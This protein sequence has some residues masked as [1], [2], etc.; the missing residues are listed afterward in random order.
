MS[1]QTVP[2]PLV[3]DPFKLLHLTL[4]PD[5]TLTRNPAV[6]LTVEATP[7]PNHPTPVLS[8]DIPINPSKNTRARIYLPR[9]A[10]DF[11]SPPATKLPLIVYYHGG[12][13]ILSSVDSIYC[14]DFC[15]NIA[16]KIPAVIVSAG[17]RLAPE[18]RLPA[19]YDDAVEALYSIKSSSED[20]LVKYA[21]FSNC[22]LMGTSAG[23]NIAYHAGLRAATV[24]DELVPLRIRGLILH[25]P[26]F[27]G[28]Q[29]SG[30]ELRNMNVPVFPLAVADMMW[31]LSLPAGADRDHE[32]CNPTV[33]GGSKLLVKV[34]SEGW[35]V[36]MIGC[37]GDLLVDRQKELVKL[38]EEKGVEVVGHFAVGGY[39]GVEV[40]DVSRAKAMYVII[41]DF[42][43][44]PKPATLA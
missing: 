1:D 27:S 34:K 21:D 7:D 18:H 35:R 38:M 2:Q 28:V 10:L 42:L 8:K 9:Q 20:W 23:S 3:I 17:Y 30:S 16:A 40:L 4:N 33:E 36:V 24:V 13:F 29:R 25:Q 32:F 44:S 11:L 39:H 22:F 26:F 31:D 5:G 37:E 41:K 14:H 43:S 12:G 19:A 6:Y 15:V